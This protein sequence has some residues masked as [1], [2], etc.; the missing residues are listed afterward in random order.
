[1]SLAQR[2]LEE[3]I[4]PETREELIQYLI[5][6]DFQC[7]MHEDFGPELLDSY[8]D[9]GFKGYR[10]FLDKELIVEYQQREEMK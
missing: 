3:P 5:D 2:V 10:H 6:S 4:S 7:I 8:L 1:M 9:T